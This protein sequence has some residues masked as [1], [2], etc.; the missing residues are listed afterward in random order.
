M[1]GSPLRLCAHE[2]DV[3]LRFDCAPTLHW[4]IHFTPWTVNIAISRREGK[5]KGVTV[6]VHHG[7]DVG[8][9][10]VIYR[11]YWDQSFR[12]F[13]RRLGSIGNAAGAACAC[14]SARRRE[15]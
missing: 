2:N 6:L 13:C 5:K 14:L 11:F 4:R 12:R 15:R 3:T 8:L 9:G 1:P 7:L 10:Q